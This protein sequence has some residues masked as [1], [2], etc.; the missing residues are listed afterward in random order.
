MQ[1]SQE[2]Q[3]RSLGQEDPLEKEMATCP[4]ILAW[5][6]PWTEKP[7]GLQSLGSQ[8]VGHGWAPRQA[9]M[10]FQFF[11]ALSANPEGEAVLAVHCGDSHGK[12]WLTL[13][14]MADVDRQ[15]AMRQA[16]CLHFASLN[17]LFPLSWSPFCRGG[18]SS[19]RGW[20]LAQSHTVSV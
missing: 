11:S 2:T 16:Q 19:T 18:H 4:S 7:G 10:S 3:V 8:R 14:V 1:E 13:P 12:Q 15:L 9:V 6:I 17:Y 20:E 5:Q